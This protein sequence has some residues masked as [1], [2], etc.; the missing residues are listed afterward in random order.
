MQIYQFSIGGHWKFL[1]S[2][3]NEFVGLWEKNMGVAK[4]F[5]VLAYTEKGHISQVRNLKTG[6]IFTALE[7]DFENYYAF[8]LAHEIGT[9]KQ[10]SKVRDCIPEE[11]NQ[12]SGE[13]IVVSEYNQNK[14]VLGPYDYEEAVKKAKSQIMNGVLGVTVKIYKAVNEV[15]LVVNVKSL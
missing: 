13:F 7:G 3:S 15:E 8:F 1:D 12:E 14:S 2:H 10:V 9:T 4:D 5:G 11:P 6:E